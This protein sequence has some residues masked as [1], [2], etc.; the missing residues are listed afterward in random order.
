MGFISR[1]LPQKVRSSVTG[2]LA[3]PRIS[4][5]RASS[6]RLC[7]IRCIIRAPSGIIIIITAR[8]ANLRFVIECS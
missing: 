7:L 6:R 2:P 8:Y 4:S 5:S 3:S 1:F